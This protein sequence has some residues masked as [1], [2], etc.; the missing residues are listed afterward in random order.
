MNRRR[1][2]DLFTIQPAQAGVRVPGVLGSAV[3]APLPG[4]WVDAGAVHVIG[5][6]VGEQAPAA[7]VEI[8]DGTA[9]V[10]RVRP[11]I[12]RPDVADALPEVPWAVTSG[13]EATLAFTRPLGEMRLG[14]RAVL[15]DG[16]VTEVGTVIGRRSWR[17]DPVVATSPPLVS[18]VVPCY[19]QAHFLRQAIGSVLAQTYPHVEVVVVDDGSDD[20]TEAIARSYEGVRCARQENAGLAGAR[21][22]GIRHTLGSLLVFLDAD[23][24][25]LPDAVQVGLDCLRA[26]PTAAFVYG[27][28][29]FIE[30]DGSPLFTPEQLCSDEPFLPLL[31]MCTIIPG[32][33]MFRRAI[34]DGGR[35]FDPSVDASADWDMYLTVTQQLPVRCHGR[36]VLE[37]RRHAD[38]MTNDPARILEAELAVLHRHTPAARDVPG[39]RQAVAAGRARSRAFHGPA[40]VEEIRRAMTTGDARA[41]AGRAWLLAR[42]DPAAIRRLVEPGS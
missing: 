5:W 32:S 35:G 6:V 9:V 28:S 7:A 42:K 14:I 4:V 30:A 24:R 26:D 40:I 17:D 33:V 1:L 41:A 10:A 11:S 20:N 8:T 37:Y 15:E 21:N 39:G 12:H 38:N 13:Y 36:T 29:R 3:D 31:E 16:E 34:F 18:V 25:L 19:N 22:T 23:D 2:N 27:R